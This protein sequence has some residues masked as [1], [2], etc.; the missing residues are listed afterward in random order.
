MC[1]PNNFDFFSETAYLLGKL[2]NRNII[3]VPV[4]SETNMSETL[5]QNFSSG[6][7]GLSHAISGPNGLYLLS[8]VHCLL[9]SEEPERNAMDGMSQSEKPFLSLPRWLLLLSEAGGNGLL[10]NPLF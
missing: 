3:I 6:I 7:S 5:E 9:T 1:H 2:L 4:T 8:F 10:S